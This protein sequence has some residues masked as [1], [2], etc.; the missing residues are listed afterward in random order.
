MILLLERMSQAGGGGGSGNYV[1]WGCH[2]WRIH[3]IW[4]VYG[5]FTMEHAIK[6]ND[7]GVKKQRISLYPH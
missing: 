7:L 2:K 4:M 5:W 1:I 3:N 6:M